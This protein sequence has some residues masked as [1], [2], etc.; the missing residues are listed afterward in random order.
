VRRPAT[1]VAI[2]CFG[3]A[4]M[5]HAAHASAKPRL[6]Y[7]RSEG[8]ERC[9][10]ERSLRDAVAERLGRE[11]FDAS[12]TSVIRVVMAPGEGE[13]VAR[14]QREDQAGRV[15]GK[16]EL[17]SAD[18]SCA[19]LVETVSLTISVMIDAAPF[20][21][22]RPPPPRRIQV[23]APAPAP[24]PADRPA[25][26]SSQLRAGAFAALTVGT[27]PAPALGIGG[28][29]GLARPSWSIDLE[30]RVD[31][32]ASKTSS[33][34]STCRADPSGG[35]V[36][37]G[38]R[39]S[40]L[41]GSAVPCYRTWYL[42]LCGIASFGALRGEGINVVGQRHDASFFAALG[43]RAALELPITGPLRLRIQSE[44]QASLASTTLSAAGSDVWTSPPVVAAF[45][46]GPLFELPVPF[47]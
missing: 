30:G 11:P 42:R 43:A 39:S 25:R 16:R 40:L 44:L 17:R 10:D 18:L 15:Q 12:G 9:P 29:L 4:A 47:P 32:P 5:S 28:L 31:L 26:A 21:D 41:Q 24:A 7:E 19:P 27:A 35:R 36:C 46:G 2:A 6:I 34:A 23:P 3:A 14:I 8:A 33:D 45:G 38:V 20:D 1:L 22:P 13:L 37:P